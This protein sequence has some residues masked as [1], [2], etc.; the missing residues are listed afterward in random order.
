MKKPLIFARCVLPWLFS[1][2]KIVQLFLHHN[3]STSL[4]VPYWTNAQKRQQWKI[5]QASL[6]CTRHVLSYTSN[7]SSELIFFFENFTNLKHLFAFSDI[8]KQQTIFP[9]IWQLILVLIIIFIIPLFFQLLIYYEELHCH[10]SM[11]KFL[12]IRTKLEIITNY[13]T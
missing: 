5:M 10:G 6:S 2:I 9:Q 3:T 11:E 13:P 1:P 7:F 12:F 8:Y 4:F